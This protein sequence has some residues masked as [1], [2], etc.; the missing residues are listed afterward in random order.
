MK[1]EF[2]RRREREREG[3]E[4]LESTER[5]EIRKLIN[6]ASK[7]NFVFVSVML[8]LAARLCVEE[9]HDARSSLRYSELYARERARD[10]WCC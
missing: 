3:N 5:Y 6:R 8:L 7:L 9:R 2:R 1:T 4:L 10:L